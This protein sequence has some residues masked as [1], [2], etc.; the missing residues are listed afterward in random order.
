MSLENLCRDFRSLQIKEL[1][2]AYC[3]KKYI[4]EL[5]GTHILYIFFLEMSF[6]FEIIL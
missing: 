1:S 5:N 4:E 6:I 3:N 2:D